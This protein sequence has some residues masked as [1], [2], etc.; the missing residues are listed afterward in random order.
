MSAG[1][2]AYGAQR[3]WGTVGWGLMGPVAGLLVDLTSSGPTKDYTPLFALCFGIGAA[4]VLVSTAALK[5]G[6]CVG[7]LLANAHVIKLKN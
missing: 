4:D 7:I 3:A 1:E 6:S 5:V 2:G